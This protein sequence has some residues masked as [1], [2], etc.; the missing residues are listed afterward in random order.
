[1]KMKKLRYTG[2]VEC[3]C[4]GCKRGFFTDLWENYSIY[5]CPEHKTKF[6]AVLEDE[7]G[8]KYELLERWETRG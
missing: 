5:E 3:P 6:R 2:I 8:N 7:K 1:M 4:P